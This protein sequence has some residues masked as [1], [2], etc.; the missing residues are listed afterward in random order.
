MT[1]F[2]WKTKKGLDLDGMKGEFRRIS[3]ELVGE[4]SKNILYKNLFQ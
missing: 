2:E 4:H 1:I 3:E